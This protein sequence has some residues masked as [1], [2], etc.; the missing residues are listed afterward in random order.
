MIWHSLLVIAL[1]GLVSAKFWMEQ[2]AHVGRSPYHPDPAYQVFRNVKDFGAVGDGGL[3]DVDG[4]SL[5]GRLHRMQ[6]TMTPQPSMQ[7]SVLVAAANLECAR[8]APFLLQPSIFHL[9]AAS[10]RAKYFNL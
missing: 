5:A 2:I 1:S 8:E 10:T 4:T 9:G 7:P 3:W 6:Y